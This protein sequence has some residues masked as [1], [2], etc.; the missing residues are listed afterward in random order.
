L[1]LSAA[2]GNPIIIIGNQT[3]RFN[4][5][6]DRSEMRVFKKSH[7]KK[8]SCKFC[9][10]SLPVVK[11]IPINSDCVLICMFVGLRSEIDTAAILKK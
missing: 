7:L 8:L 6:P 10:T 5:L 3:Y 2:K 11:K 4:E 1:K 9:H